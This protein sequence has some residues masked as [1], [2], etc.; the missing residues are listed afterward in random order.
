MEA[1]AGGND[2]SSYKDDDDSGG[3]GGSGYAFTSTSTVVSGYQLTSAYY[4]TN[5]VLNSGTETF[6]SPAGTD[7]TGHNGNGYARLTLIGS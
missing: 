6:K 5:A 2:Y 1:E 4:M 7:E 3:G